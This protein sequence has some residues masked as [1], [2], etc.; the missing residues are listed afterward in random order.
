MGGSGGPSNDPSKKKVSDDGGTG[1]GGEKNGGGDNCVIRFSAR[2]HGPVPG[3][4]NLLTVGEFLSV[5]RI[6]GPPIQLRLLNASG[7]EVG[8][9]AGQRELTRVLSCMEDGHT[10][11]AEVQSS[12]GSLI[13]VIV[14]NA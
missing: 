3:V 5:V 9:L 1:A 11:L 4:A 8:S 10:Y 6:E 13:T 7:K 12:S 14:R 2:I